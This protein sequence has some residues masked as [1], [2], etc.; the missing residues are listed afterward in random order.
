MTVK[1]V[2]FVFY[3]KYRN[4]LE[5][6][7]KKVAVMQPYFLPYI[8][9]F[10]LINAVDEFIVYDNIQ[11]SKK[12][13]FHRNRML[14][15]GKDE[16]FSL[17][18]KKDSDYLDVKDRYLSDSWKDEREKVL[19]KVKENYRKAPHFNEIYPLIENLFRFN[20]PN[21][22]DF[23]FNSIQVLCDFLEIKTTL[24]ISSTLVIDHSLKSQDKVI[25]LVEAVQGKTYIN[26]IGGFD[27]YSP[28]DFNKR[29]IKLEFHK[30]KPLQYPQFNKE[31]V[32]WLSIMD[33][34]M[35]NDKIQVIEWL[36]AFDILVK[37]E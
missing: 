14:Q 35:F 16:Y 17:T 9:Y 7:Y 24:T 31:F 34:L 20:E 2:T 3:T 18:L 36:N 22:F 37:D 12:G 6:T 26:P 32:P 30:A 8:G 5:L 27:L 4:P 29:G 13:W 28:S 25:A 15:D 33:L 19:R 1:P 23:I 21:L 11:F 10:Q